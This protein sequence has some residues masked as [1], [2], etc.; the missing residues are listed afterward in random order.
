MLGLT[1]KGKNEAKEK[2]WTAKTSDNP[3]SRCTAGIAPRG[4]FRKRAEAALR[5]IGVVRMEMQKKGQNWQSDRGWDNRQGATRGRD[6]GRG[7]GQGLLREGQRQRPAQRR[8]AQQRAS[9]RVRWMGL[10]SFFLGF[11]WGCLQTLAL[12]T[13]QTGLAWDWSHWRY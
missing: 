2:E 12:Q 5:R 10:W 8:A 13:D 4:R 7:R 9:E 6:T 3:N 1:I 11:C